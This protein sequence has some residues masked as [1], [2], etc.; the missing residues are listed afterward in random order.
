MQDDERSCRSQES[1]V[2][3]ESKGIDKTYW[4]EEINKESP[5]VHGTKSML[6]TV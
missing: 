5:E 4:D 6:K 1:G 2:E 3:E